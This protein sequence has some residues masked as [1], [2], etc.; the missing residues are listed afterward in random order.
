MR[1]FGEL[2]LLAALG[3]V[4]HSSLCWNGHPHGQGWMAVKG[5]G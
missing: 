2:L 4:G 1:V 5:Q 3:P